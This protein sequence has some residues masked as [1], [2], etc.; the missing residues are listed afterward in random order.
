MNAPC[1][2][3]GFS[4]I[5]YRNQ[6]AWRAQAA[7]PGREAGQVKSATLD[8]HVAQ[9]VRIELIEEQVRAGGGQEKEQTNQGCE[10][11]HGNLL[12]YTV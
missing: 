2:G 11:Q 3:I 9:I 7:R 4:I 8:A 5:S 6:K 10:D 12:S 1:C